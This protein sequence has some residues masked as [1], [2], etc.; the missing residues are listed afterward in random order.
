MTNQQMFATKLP[1]LQFLVPKLSASTLKTTLRPRPKEAPKSSS[2]GDVSCF[3][4]DEW[5]FSLGKANTGKLRQKMEY[6]K[7]VPSDIRARA[8]QIWKMTWHLC[9][10]VSKRTK[11][12]NY[13]FFSNLQKI[14]T[15]V[16]AVPRPRFFFF[17]DYQSE[18]WGL[19]ARHSLDTFCLSRCI[20]F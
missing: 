12:L 16:A 4:E 17:F 20:Y 5:K 7:L 15:A 10:V 18:I 14:H 19:F 9:P 13:R 11:I 8:L 6:R 2:M 1:R 3:K